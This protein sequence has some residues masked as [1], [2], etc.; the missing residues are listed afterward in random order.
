MQYLCLIRANTSTYPQNS[1]WFKRRWS[2]LLEALTV[3]WRGHEVTT[4][5]VL[6]NTPTS[7]MEGVLRNMPIPSVKWVL[8]NTP[9]LNR[10]DLHSKAITHL[11]T[12]EQRLS[13]REDALVR[14]WLWFCVCGSG[15][16]VEGS[17]L[18]LL[19]LLLLWF[20]FEV[21]GVGSC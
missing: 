15:F 11:V 10:N 20:A 14:C 2:K 19:Q 21:R 17:G 1:D 3:H 7:C 4:T 18:R 5:W 12:I 16:V 8:R 13:L 9:T 6:R